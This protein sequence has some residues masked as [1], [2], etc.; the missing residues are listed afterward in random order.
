MSPRALE[1]KKSSRLSLLMSETARAGPSVES[2]FGRRR[3]KSEVDE[4]VFAVGGVAGDF[5]SY[6]R[7]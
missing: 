1:R 3:S 5:G 2:I 7:E 6:V 4:E